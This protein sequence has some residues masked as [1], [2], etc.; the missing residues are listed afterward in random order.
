MFPIQTLFM[1]TVQC[2][3]G[4]AGDAAEGRAGCLQLCPRELHLAQDLRADLGHEAP[5]KRMIFNVQCCIQ[6]NRVRYS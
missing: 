6:Q 3:A 2:N 5:G 4:V 1:D